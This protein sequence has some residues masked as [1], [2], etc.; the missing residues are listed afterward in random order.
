MKYFIGILVSVIYFY[1][2]CWSINILLDSYLE[3]GGWW[4]FPTWVIIWGSFVFG[5]GIMWINIE[6]EKFD[7][8]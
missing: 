1:F 3:N 4:Q 2:I 5:N 8:N 6:K 7:A